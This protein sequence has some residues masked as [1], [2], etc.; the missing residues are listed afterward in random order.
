MLISENPI[1]SRVRAE[2]SIASRSALVGSLHRDKVREVVDARQGRGSPE[3]EF[4]S[5]LSRRSRSLLL[6]RST[7]RFQSDDGGIRLEQEIRNMVSRDAPH[8][9]LSNVR[10]RRIVLILS[11]CLLITCYTVYARPRYSP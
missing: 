7:V 4:S 10:Q 2:R 6:M 1:A 9:Y 8:I 11:I 5:G 3:L